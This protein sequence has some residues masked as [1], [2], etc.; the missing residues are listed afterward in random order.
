MFGRLQVLAK[1]GSEVTKTK[2]LALLWP[3]EMP[4][5]AADADDSVLLRHGSVRYHIVTW[6]H[7]VHK[8]KHATLNSGWK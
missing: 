6:I 7:M 3:L 4:Q 8:C 2:V 1:M 5:V